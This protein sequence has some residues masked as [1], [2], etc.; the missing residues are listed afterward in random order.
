MSVGG[1]SWLISKS[2]F[3]QC[4]LILR[5]KTEKVQIKKKTNNEFSQT[6]FGLLFK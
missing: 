6:T 3:F 1:D 2:L 5:N 4:I